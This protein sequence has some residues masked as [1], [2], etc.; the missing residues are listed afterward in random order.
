MGK[1]KGE[2][3]GTP[4]EQ[5]SLVLSIRF[6]AA[7]S[8]VLE[9]TW[10]STRHPPVSDGRGRPRRPRPHAWRAGRGRG[11]GCGPGGRAR[12]PRGA[13]GQARGPRSSG[14]GRSVLVARFAAWALCLREPGGDRGLAVHAPAPPALSVLA[15]VRAPRH[16]WDPP[17]ARTSHPVLCASLQFTQTKGI[18]SSFWMDRSTSERLISPTC[19]TLS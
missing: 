8:D 17:R 4:R 16:T 7:G 9:V 18:S 1:D 19:G 11:R 14:S 2:A 6:N 5:R 10:A 3:L 13:P 15:C 12:P